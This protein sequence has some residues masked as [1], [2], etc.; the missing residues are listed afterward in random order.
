MQSR[1]SR[2]SSQICG[3][4]WRNSVYQYENCTSPGLNEFTVASTNTNVVPSTEVTYTC[5]YGYQL[6][7]GDLGTRVCQLGG[8]WP[9]PPPACEVTPTSTEEIMTSEV[10][11]IATSAI[12]PLECL[13][14]CSQVGKS[15][16][17]SARGMNLTFEEL[18]EMLKPDLDF[19]KKELGVNKYNTS[20]MRRSKI[21]APDDRIS[22]TSV[23]YVGVV[24]ICIITVMIVF[25]DIL[26]CLVA[27]F[28]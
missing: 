15:N 13:C 6:P 2:N 28:K 27:K 26:G 21:S 3:G 9:K 5:E 25:L 10:T 20:R 7:A 8:T 16:W 4:D 12:S 17:G 11:S 1:M 22:A 23:G 19:L 18:R 24:F 14:P